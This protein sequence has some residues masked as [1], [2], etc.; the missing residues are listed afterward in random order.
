MCHALGSESSVQVSPCV[1]DAAVGFIML[2]KI[3]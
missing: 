1:A 3:V 2:I